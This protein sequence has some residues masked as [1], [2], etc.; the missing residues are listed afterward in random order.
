MFC[1]S[2]V[3]H[4]GKCNEAEVTANKRQEDDK[5]TLVTFNVM[6]VRD[7]ET[8]MIMKHKKRI[9]IGGVD[10]DS[11]WSPN[12]LLS[13]SGLSFVPYS[14]ATKTLLLVSSNKIYFL[15]IHDPWLNIHGLNLNISI[16][17]IFIYLPGPRH[18]DP[19]PLLRHYGSASY[20]NGLDI[21]NF[22]PGL[23]I[24]VHRIDSHPSELYCPVPYEDH[25][26]P[27]NGIAVDGHTPDCGLIRLAH[28]THTIH[29]V[30]MRDSRVSAIFLTSAVDRQEL[31]VTP[32]PMPT[33]PEEGDLDVN[34]S[35]TPAHAFSMDISTATTSLAST[36]MVQTALPTSVPLPLVSSLVA[37]YL[38][39]VVVVS[40]VANALVVVVRVYG[41]RRPVRSSHVC[42]LCLAVSDV[43]FS[44]MVHTVMILAALGVDP[45]LLFN[46]AG[47]NYY[48]FSAM[49]FGTFSMCIHASVS[50]IRYINICHAEK[51]EW[52][53]LKYVYVLIAGS[54]FYSVIWALGPLLQWGRYETFEFGCT[55]AFSDPSRSGRS[56]VTCAF[57]FVLLL[58][59][60]VVVTCYS[61]IVAKAR[62]YQREMSR[63]AGD[64][65]SAAST[66]ER[67]EW[68]GRRCGGL[69]PHLGSIRRTQR[70]LRLH[71]KLVRM[72]MVVAG[73]YILGWLPYATVCMW[74]TY[75]DYS[76]IPIELRVGASL[77]CKSATAYNPF[78][79]YFM[80]E[81]FRADLRWLGHR[82]GFISH[83][84]STYQPS[85][86]SSSRSSMKKSR[87]RT[88][89]NS[90]IHINM[91]R[92]DSSSTFFTLANP[93]TPP[94]PLSLLTSPDASDDRAI[95]VL[96]SLAS[97]SSGSRRTSSCLR[98]SRSSLQQMEITKSQ[99][100]VTKQ[101]ITETPLSAT[102][103]LA[104]SEFIVDYNLKQTL[105]NMPCD[106]EP[107]HP[108]CRR[109]VSFSISPK[110]SPRLVRSP[111]EITDS[112]KR[113][114][115]KT[116]RSCSLYG[117]RDRRSYE[118]YQQRKLSRDQFYMNTRV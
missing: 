98:L 75:G 88:R 65:A 86:R 46:T 36:S 57:V 29:P 106:A 26:L 34:T 22:A 63:I 17:E 103:I 43:A 83:P 90:F 107:V 105:T 72:S 59:L 25:R 108:S 40:V 71:N 69:V 28:L 117:H 1:P 7:N 5:E 97:F 99:Q 74:A 116:I 18:E 16:P 80:S 15:N 94:T 12:P 13:G 54:A 31:Q 67:S 21:H 24:H 73:G 51:V 81:G 27:H 39:I 47:C 19:G 101:V 33:V 42:T 100:Q 61:L 20:A 87:D 112:N 110:A 14:R 96:P 3:G 113:M 37:V 64:R 95:Y 2:H 23:S 92:K 8:E 41:R 58:P 44:V 76:A 6:E 85:L 68:K 118:K 104:D 79:Y 93:D 91:S 56:F 109:S 9:E 10:N 77:I 55:L 50:I 52:L 84:G 102:E 62:E 115:I 66:A 11:E 89:E 49:F 111:S 114:P 70:S 82:A 60:G 32:T 30:N 48:G 53:K 38:I 45:L 4:C 78:I 35:H